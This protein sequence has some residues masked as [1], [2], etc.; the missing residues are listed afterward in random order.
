M[1]TYCKHATNTYTKLDI[2]KSGDTAF[3][4]WKDKSGNT[5]LKKFT[6]ISIHKKIIH[7]IL[8]LDEQ[9]AIAK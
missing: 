4:Y 2:I 8:M 7:I 6:S 1:L 9:K 5:C 3:D